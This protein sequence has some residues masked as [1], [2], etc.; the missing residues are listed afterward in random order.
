MPPPYYKS[1][2]VLYAALES[3]PNFP[4]SLRIH[5]PDTIFFNDH[6]FPHA[7]YSSF[8]Y[9]LK[10]KY[11]DHLNIP[12]VCE[13]LLKKSTLTSTFAFHFETYSEFLTK[14]EFTLRAKGWMHA[15]T[16]HPTEI[17]WVLQMYNV[18]TMDKTTY[19]TSYLQP[20]KHPFSL[21]TS[22]TAIP[23]AERQKKQTEPLKFNKMN[24][25]Q[26]HTYQAEIGGAKLSLRDPLFLRMKRLKL[27]LVSQ[28]E[29]CK[30]MTIINTDNPTLRC[31]ICEFLNGPEGGEVQLIN[32]LGYHLKGRE[33]TWMIDIAGNVYDKR[34]ESFMAKKLN[35][36]LYTEAR[37][38]RK[39]PY[40]RGL[41]GHVAHDNRRYTVATHR[42]NNPDTPEE[43]QDDDSINKKSILDDPEQLRRENAI[44]AVFYKLYKDMKKKLQRPIDV[45]KRIDTDENGTISPKELRVGLLKDLGF[46]FTDEEFQTVI[47]IIDADGSGEIEYGELTKRIKDSDPARRERLKKHALRR[48]KLDD[49]RLK[50]QVKKGKK[51][52]KKIQFSNMVNRQNKSLKMSEIRAQKEAVA[53]ASSDTKTRAN[54]PTSF[55]PPV[56]QKSKKYNKKAHSNNSGSSNAI[57]IKN[58]LNEKT[59]LL[60]AAQKLV[61]DLQM[62]LGQS[63]QHVPKP[64]IGQS[65]SNHNS[66]NTPLASRVVA[67]N[68]NNKNNNLLAENTKL[69]IEISKLK[70]VLSEERDANL[71]SMRRHEEEND[72]FVSKLEKI[73]KE[74][75]LEKQE[76]L[77]LENMNENL[78]LKMEECK[79]RLSKLNNIMQG[80][81]NNALKKPVANVMDEI[82]ED[83]EEEDRFDKDVLQYVA[84]QN[85][86]MFRWIFLTYAEKED[87]GVDHFVQLEDVKRFVFDIQ[88]Q[89]IDANKLATL[90]LRSN[91]NVEYNMDFSHFVELMVRI[92]DDAYHRKEKVFSDRFTKF[93]AEHVVPLANMILGDVQ[94]D[95]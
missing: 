30:N 33:P 32:V 34:I 47:E 89:N 6:K 29:K 12:R 62:A 58:E 5:V 72:N 16:R 40:T 10:K 83:G 90:Y 39:S 24:D 13:E 38:P 27:H 20:G 65:P 8:N 48:E 41:K 70:D 37:T 4:T 31:L 49:Q 25:L 86:P 79:R 26:L 88:L 3:G 60:Q 61:K 77:K 7:W 94:D 91:G 52:R 57:A 55:V 2:Q 15:E 92:A 22:I 11:N 74:L 9:R 56:A 93:I 80:R 54:L 35:F 85:E 64:P 84:S 66:D 63:L 21:I 23:F 19:L 71:K 81:T 18:P 95:I 42:Q 67:S 36:Q 14:R 50:R 46:V 87:G 78:K 59:A 45:F 53:E 17:P 69:K 73:E 43:N 44:N 28:V 82:E 1:W 68:D 51:E 76:K 75:N